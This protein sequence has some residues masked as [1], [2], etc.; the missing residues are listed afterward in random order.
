VESETPEVLADPETVQ[1]FQRVMT[2][3]K[4]HGKCGSYRYDDGSFYIGDFDENGVRYTFYHLSEVL[5]LIL[6]VIRCGV[7]HL[8]MPNGSTY[9]GHFLKGLPNTVGVMRFSDSSR[10]EGIF[11]F[12]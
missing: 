11:D 7:G 1:S 2:L 3:K 9:D 8:E 12:E 10:F 5:V 6:Y 4:K